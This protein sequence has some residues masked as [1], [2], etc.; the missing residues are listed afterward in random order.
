MPRDFLELQ[1]LDED[2]LFLFALIELP[3]RGPCQSFPARFLFL[4][5]TWFSV[6]KLVNF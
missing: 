6:D 1:V 3:S 2:T 5:L 4:S